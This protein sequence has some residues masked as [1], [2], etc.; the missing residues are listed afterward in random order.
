VE[1]LARA[2]GS[3]DNILITRTASGDYQGDTI[4]EIATER[5]LDPVDAMCELLVEEHLT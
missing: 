1:N 5:N 3:W 4:E 2:A